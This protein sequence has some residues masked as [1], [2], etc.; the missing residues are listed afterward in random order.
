METPATY[1]TTTLITSAGEL[2]SQIQ[3][4]IDERDAYRAKCARQGAIIA[5]LA[6]MMGELQA[7]IDEAPQE[8]MTAPEADRWDG[9]ARPDDALI[10]QWA[11]EYDA[12]TSCKDIAKRYG[13]AKYRI[14][15]YISRYRRQQRDAEPETP[16]PEAEPEPATAND[17]ALDY[18]DHDDDTIAEWVR[19]IDAGRTAEQVADRYGEDPYRVRGLVRSWREEHGETVKAFEAA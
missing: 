17:P 19:L 9:N 12:G 5:K 11:E 8:A 18:P 3:T 6:D 4:I 10:A 7:F 14:A 13:V 15:G 16:E 2:L 1:T